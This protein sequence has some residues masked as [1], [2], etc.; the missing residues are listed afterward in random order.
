MGEQE[1]K[2]EILLCHFAKLGGHKTPRI[3]IGAF[4][5]KAY[6]DTKGWESDEKEEE[7]VVVV[8]SA[9]DK[10]PCAFQTFTRRK[11]KAQQQPPQPAG[12]LP[13]QKTVMSRE[14]TPAELAGIAAKF[15]PKARKRIEAWSACLWE[16]GV[17]CS[18]FTTYMCVIHCI[19]LCGLKCH[20]NDL[21]FIIL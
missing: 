14:C 9:K 7:D 6:W 21:I 18:R 12:Q 20:I 2:L 10:D 16:T 15:Q 5:T 17:W 1:C 8:D 19:V 13:L 3:K 11:A 4:M